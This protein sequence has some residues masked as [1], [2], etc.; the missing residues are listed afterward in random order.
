MLIGN[1][2][3]VQIEAK[4]GIAFPDDIREFMN[5][6][7]QERF[8]D[9]APGKWHC[10]ELPFVMVCGDM[11]IAEKIYNSVKDKTAECK[12]QLL[13]SLQEKHENTNI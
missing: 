5:A 6:T 9:V 12:E 13:F 7:H 8:D 1:L 2:T 4:L 11:A 3:V 10:A